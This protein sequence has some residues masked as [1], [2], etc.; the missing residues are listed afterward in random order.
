MV[1]IDPCRG[2]VTFS[3]VVI[4]GGGKYDSLHSV[5]ESAAR[6]SS[7][8]NDYFTIRMGS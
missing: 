1:V 5:Y 3:C 2:S 6:N 4:N 8:E 7:L